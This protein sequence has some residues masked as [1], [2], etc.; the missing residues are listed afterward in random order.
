MAD[1]KPGMCNEQGSCK[2]FYF[3]TIICQSNSYFGNYSFEN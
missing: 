2:A 1:S 3:P